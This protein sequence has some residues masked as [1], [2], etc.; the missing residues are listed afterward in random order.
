MG[1]DQLVD[2]V[3]IHVDDFEAQ[4]RDLEAISR[5]RDAPI[6]VDDECELRSRASKVLHDLGRRDGLG[7]DE[8][9]AQELLC[10]QRLA[11]ETKLEQ[12]QHVAGFEV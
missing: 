7:N 2:A 4:P 12:V 1:D 11:R 9:L 8:M 3:A 5:S 10:W 6:L